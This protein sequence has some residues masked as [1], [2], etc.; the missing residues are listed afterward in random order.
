M[1]AVIKTGHSIGRS[2]QLESAVSA[3]KI[4]AFSSGEFVGMVTDDPDCKIDLKTFRCAIL[5]NH[6]EALK[7]GQD[8]YQDITDTFITQ[9]QLQ[10]FRDNDNELIITEKQNNRRYKQENAGEFLFFT[11]KIITFVNIEVWLIYL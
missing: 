3:Y 2:K 6:H 1:V 4:S 10:L 7:K 8:S 5:N 9:S 11:N